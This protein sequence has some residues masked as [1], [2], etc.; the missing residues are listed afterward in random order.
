MNSGIT[1]IKDSFLYFN[2]SVL[3]KFALHECVFPVVDDKSILTEELRDLHIVAS[4]SSSL[5][6]ADF[7]NASHLLWGFELSDKDLL[8]VHFTDTESEG[9]S[10]SDWK[11]IW[12][13]YNDQDN[14]NVDEADHLGDECF[15]VHKGLV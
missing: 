9:Y 13:R 7:L 14:G 5:A 3:L 1:V 12:H 11:T 10:N 2:E 15:P 4:Q 8:F 6:T